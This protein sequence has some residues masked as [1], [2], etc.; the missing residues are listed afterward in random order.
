VTQR[1]NAVIVADAFIILE[2]IINE[3]Y[4]MR[5]NSAEVLDLFDT[6]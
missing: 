2:V 1:L 5:S 4:M 6:L 3:T